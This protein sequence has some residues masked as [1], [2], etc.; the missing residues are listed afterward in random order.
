[1]AV[2]AVGA[3]IGVLVDGFVTEEGVGD[4]EMVLGAEVKEAD[5]RLVPRRGIAPG[6]EGR[7]KAG[8]IGTGVGVKV[9]EDEKHVVRGDFKDLGMEA[10]VELAVS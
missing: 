9:P 3:G 8:A 4:T 5:A 6:A 1:M 10:V 2:L 7:V